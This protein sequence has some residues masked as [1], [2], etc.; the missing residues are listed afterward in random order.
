[1]LPRTFVDYSKDLLKQYVVEYCSLVLDGNYL[2][3]I[4]FVSATCSTS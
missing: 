3:K 4:T 2:F 1:M